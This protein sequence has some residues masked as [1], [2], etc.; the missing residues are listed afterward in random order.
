MIVWRENTP[1]V[2]VCGHYL[3]REANSFLEKNRAGHSLTV[4]RERSS[5]KENCELRG[6]DNVLGQIGSPLFRLGTERRKFP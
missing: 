4:F 2:F 6:T 1:T 3:F 5:V